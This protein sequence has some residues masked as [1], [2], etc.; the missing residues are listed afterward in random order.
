MKNLVHTEIQFTKKL[1]D[2]IP[3]FLD[4]SLLPPAG[5]DF[6]NSWVV[7]PT[8]DRSSLYRMQEIQAPNLP[9]QD[10]LNITHT[11]IWVTKELPV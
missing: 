10:Q 3:S 9:D 5:V 6:Q 1:F 11:I 2:F 7:L 8:N 4:P